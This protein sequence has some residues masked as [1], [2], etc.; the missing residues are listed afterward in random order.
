MKKASAPVLPAWHRR[1]SCG[2]T[3]IE[4]LITLVVLAILA[5]VVYPSFMDSIRKGRRSE[6]VASISAIQQAQERFRANRTSYASS[7]TNGSSDSPPGL[8]LSATS[9]SGLY[10]LSLSDVT[11]LNYTVTATAASGKSQASDDNCVRMAMKVESGRLSYGSAGSS[12]SIDFMDAKRC[13]S[14]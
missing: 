12:G 8:G 4:M 14:R 3:L 6:A 2:F 9:S 13:W 1:M 5:A 7:L 11:A 10:A